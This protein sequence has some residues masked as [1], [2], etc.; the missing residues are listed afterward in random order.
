LQ[1]GIVDNFPT[2]SRENAM[3]MMTRRL[4]SSAIRFVGAL[5]LSAMPSLVAAPAAILGSTG[6][7]AAQVFPS[8]PITM[9]VPYPAGGVFDVLARIMAEPM[10]GSLGQAVVIEN[11]GGAGGSIGVGRVARAAPDGYTLSFGSDQ[12]FVV[13]GAVYPL[14]YDVVKDF[15]PVML[16]ASSPTL[17]VSK[18]AVPANDLKELIAWLKANHN[19][20]AQGHNGAGGAQHLCGIDLQNTT[21]TRWQFVPYR[22][23]APALQDMVG[24]Q[25]DLMCPSPGSSL[26]MVRSG[27]LRAY[28]VTASTRLASAQEI[29]TVDEAGLPGL[30][31][32]FWGGLLAPKGTPKNVIAKLNL[33]A[34]SALADPAVRQRISDLGM[35][36]PPGEQ[37]TPE[38]LGALQ[39]ADIAKWWP[40][41]KAANIKGE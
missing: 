33:A 17:I 26:A 38:A 16:L 24:G 21:G 5:A 15:E 12:Q 4:R 19:K 31:I 40:I 2:E 6:T 36:T 14:Q 32:S 3:R 30:Y 41:I 25:I 1:A 39:K 8:R 29:P 13:N 23:T 37:Q 28:A 9:I 34:R 18:A 20:V 22:G 10:R 7:A 27:S 11:V 35:E